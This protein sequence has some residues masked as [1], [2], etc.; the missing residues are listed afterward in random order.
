MVFPIQIYSDSE[1]VA[2]QLAKLGLTTDQIV[3]AVLQGQAARNNST[4]HHPS[5][6]GGT[7]AFFEVVRSLRD[8]L[9]PKGWVA[10]SICNLSM[11]V[12]PETNISIAVSGG[13]R[14]TGTAEGYP[15]TRNP[16]GEQ[17]KKYVVHNQADL[18]EDINE[19]ITSEDEMYSQ[20]WLLLYYFDVGNQE[21]RM[22][23]SLPVRIYDYARVCG[24]KT[25]ILIEPISLGDDDI[26]IEPE[27]SPDID[28]EIQRQA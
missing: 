15:T 16:K 26:A 10:L 22:E 18:F 12:N 5:N 28:I 20:T 21:L 4:L 1:S 17:T 23:L 14:E 25:R 24:W 6:A 3:Q 11:V 27:Y 19:S 2:S 7:M 9:V 13:S 8:I